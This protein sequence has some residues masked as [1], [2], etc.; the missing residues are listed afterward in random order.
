MST[1]TEQVCGQVAGYLNGDWLS[2]DQIEQLIE[3]SSELY[4]PCC[5]SKDLTRHDKLESRPLITDT[6]RKYD[7]KKCLRCERVF[8][9]VPNFWRQF[10]RRYWRDS[11]VRYRLIAGVMN[12]LTRENRAAK[13]V[14]S[15]I[16][17][18]RLSV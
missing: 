12:V 14:R 9:G 15:G 17:T 7:F 10:P 4:C 3:S 18:W 16:V 6:C 8:L 11:D 13:R 5:G 2:R 1:L